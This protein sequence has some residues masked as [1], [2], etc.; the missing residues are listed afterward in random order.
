MDTR[1]RMSGA[2]LKKARGRKGLSQLEFAEL[3][4]RSESWVSKIE[5]NSIRLKDLDLAERIADVLGV[6]LAG[7]LGLDTSVSG[8][9]AASVSGGHT[10]VQSAVPQVTDAREWEMWDSM[11]RRWFLTQ[12]A[13][14]ALAVTEALR[15]GPSDAV[16]ATV[17]ERDGVDEQTVASLEQ[18]VLGWRQAYRTASAQTLLGPAH[19]TLNLLVEMA[20]DAG[21][22]QDRVVSLIGQMSALVGTMLMLDMA[23]FEGARHFLTVSARAGH[24]SRD[25]ELTALALGCRAFHA[26]YGQEPDPRESLRFAEGAL[27][28]AET[29]IHPRTHA[30][31]QA[32]TSEMRATAGEDSSCRRALD[33][34]AALLGQPERDRP[35]LGIGAFGTAK[36]TAYRGGDLSRLGQHSQAQATLMEAL[37]A[38][39]P[40]MRK[41]RCTAF[42]DLAESFARSGDIDAACEHA[43]SALTI[44][45]KTRHADS[46]KRVDVLHRKVTMTRAPAARRLGEKLIGCKAVVT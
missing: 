2:W 5:T 19:S 45:Q 6:P 43:G 1:C 17:F 9:A 22:R 20:P 24:Q 16:L 21:P 38:L 41:H 4:G 8:G 46:L 31:L 13:L 29:G 10:R 25:A 7:V 36:L 44:I 34:S 27:V 15:P 23:D 14:A 42:I 11:K 28:A 26:A 12:A 39:D 30:W 32:V 37:H 33:I 40:S 3:I 35:W 18:V